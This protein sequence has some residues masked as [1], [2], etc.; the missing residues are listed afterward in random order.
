MEKGRKGE[1]SVLMKKE[2][3]NDTKEQGGVFSAVAQIEE[4]A[5]RRR[6]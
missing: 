1:A 4:G 3:E 5:G 6:D 2:G